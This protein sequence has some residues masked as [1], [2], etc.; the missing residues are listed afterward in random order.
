MKKITSMFMLVLF[1]LLFSIT[2]FAAKSGSWV[3]AADG[4]WWFQCT[5]GTYP[6]NGWEVIDNVYYYFDADGWMLADTT[7]PDGYYVDASGAWVQNYGIRNSSASADGAISSA[8]ALRG[9]VADDILDKYQNSGQVRKFYPNGN[10]YDVD[11]LA[12]E[13]GI[14]AAGSIQRLPSATAQKANSINARHEWCFGTDSGNNTANNFP[15]YYSYY[16]V[17]AADAGTD[18]FRIRKRRSDD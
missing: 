5:D 9:L 6:H 2:A 15:Y 8:Q 17:L 1:I 4:R 7:T 3:Q 10:N 16:T 14:W 13:L 12:Y 11:E 18:P